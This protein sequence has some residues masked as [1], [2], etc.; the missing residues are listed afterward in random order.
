MK[1]FYVAGIFNN[2]E[3]VWKSD[4]ES[5]EL[6][7]ANFELMGVDIIEIADAKHTHLCPYCSGIANGTDHDLL[8]D[9]CRSVFGHY[10]YSEL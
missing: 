4:C 3:C 2:R 6:C 5:E 1:T 9:D 8:C 7:I 10:F